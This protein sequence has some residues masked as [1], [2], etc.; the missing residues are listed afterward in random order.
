MG[1]G[2]V[3]SVGGGSGTKWVDI[4]VVS[5]LVVVSVNQKKQEG[6]NDVQ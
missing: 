1:K 5:V 6:E 4:I 2:D 3:G